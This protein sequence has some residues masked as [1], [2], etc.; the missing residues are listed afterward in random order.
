MSNPTNEPTRDLEDGI[1]NPARQPRSSVPSFLFIS[2]VLFMLM[3]GCGDEYAATR[4]IYVNGLQSL[5][6]Q[7]SNF[8]TWL[9]GTDSNFTLPSQD[10]NTTP[11]VA[12]FISTGHEVDPKHESYY[13]NMTGFWH[14]DL[15]PHNLTALNATEQI[16][17]WRHLSEQFILPTNLSA[18]PD[19]SGPWNWTR[20]NKLTLNVGDKLV[21]L[22]ESQSSQAKSIAIIH[23]KL[24]LSDRKSSGEMRLDFEGIHVLS[25]G[26]VYAYAECTGYVFISSPC[27]QYL[28][29][30]HSRKDSLRTCMKC[31][32]A[33]PQYVCHGR[34]LPF[35]LDDI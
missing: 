18:I 23:G 16:S 22:N 20:S 26:S 14:G 12:A 2:F 3:S 21:P 1:D 34:H 11:L 29:G 31:L 9:N 7:L 35:D 10:P 25:T 6:H 28:R 32:L 8:T 17:P 19:L 4:D 30:S 13:S 33:M 27:N 15:Q 5:N 24:D